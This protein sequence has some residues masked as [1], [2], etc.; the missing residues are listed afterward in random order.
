M[1][2]CLIVFFVTLLFTFAGAQEIPGRQPNAAPRSDIV[3]KK[4]LPA[5]KQYDQVV[6][7]PFFSREAS[8]DSIVVLNNNGPGKTVAEV[9]FFDLSGVERLSK[10]IEVP[11][12]TPF[13]FHVDDL[14]DESNFR[15]ASGNVRVRYRGRLMQMTG[16]ISISSERQHISYES[17]MAGD[18]AS[19]RLAAILSVPDVQSQVLLALTNYSSET[20]SVAVEHKAN[21]D[22][23]A[24]KLR[25]RETRLLNRRDL[26]DRREASFVG[27][28][29]IMHDGKPGELG[30]TGVVLNPQTGFSSE[31]SLVDPATVVSSKLAGA[32]LLFGAYGGRE[33][34]LLGLTFRTPLLLANTGREVSD[35]VVRVGY[36]VGEETR[37]ITVASSSIKPGDVQQLDLARLLFDLGVTQKVEEAGVDIEY[38]GQPG[39]IIAK[40][41]SMDQTGDFAFDTPLKDPLAGFGRVGGSYPFRLDGSYNTTL[42]LKNFTPEEVWAIV[43]I[44]IDGGMNYQPERVRIAP[45]QTI[46]LDVK[47]IR[48]TEIKD[49]KNVRMPKAGLYGKVM[50]YE[51]KL[52][53]LIGRNEVTNA[54]FGFTGSFSCPNCACPPWRTTSY[55]APSSLIDFAGQFGAPFRPTYEATDCSYQQWGPYDL[56]YS[57]WNWY[58]TVSSVASVTSGGTV[59]CNSAGRSFISSLIEIPDYPADDYSPCLTTQDSP[60]GQLDVQPT[61]Q[62]PTSVT[63]GQVASPTISG[64]GAASIL[65]EF[66]DGGAGGPVTAS[67]NGGAVWSG[68]MVTS[69]TVRA[70]VTP[71]TGSPTVVQCF[72]SVT[73]RTDWHKNPQSAQEVFNGALVISGTPVILPV[74]PQ[75]TGSDAGLGAHGWTVGWSNLIISRPGSGPNTGY[76]FFANKPTYTPDFSR[77]I[78]NPDLKN[79]SS[80]FS[81]MNC[82]ANGFISQSN[83]L[84]QTKRH[85]YDH[86]VQSH[87]AKYV[88]V[89]NNTAN[90][91]GDYLESAFGMPTLSDSDFAN[92]VTSSL[93]A[94]V[95]QMNTQYSGFEPYAVNADA[96]NNFLGNINFP[97]YAPCP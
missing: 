26:I 69:G 51:Q 73:S 13:R 45:F 48:D 76:A 15:L 79:A 62:C 53:S 72:I 3:N 75:P 29:T 97:P 28:M 46:A 32:H 30:G 93:N 44:R 34:A 17:R 20:I 89:M 90:N 95:S 83:L 66:L 16:Q 74:P 87:H 31:L 21:A 38:S 2:T 52:G 60:Q 18:A 78:L 22:K 64:L 85:E 58:S 9:T 7:F 61:I 43:Q 41:T 54:D 84:A 25:P 8:Y 4:P 82:G 12:G 11:D 19:S 14:E 35:V 23:H 33:P 27:L 81:T 55:M 77:Y 42:Y 65:W 37:S 92:A 86:P 94:R 47:Q 56:F 88:E 39:T 10:K 6:N 1:R 67:N 96:N 57:A 49:M 40:L 24:F 71:P 50:W 63:R 80:Q 5:P 91:L 36:T 70:T 59:S 68:T